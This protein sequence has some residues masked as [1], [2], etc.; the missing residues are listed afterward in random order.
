M[1]DTITPTTQ[2]KRVLRRKKKPLT[3]K[4]KLVKESTEKRFKIEKLVFVWQEKLFSH[5]KIPLQTLERAAIYLQPKTY[6]EVV[7][8]RAVQAWCGYPLCPDSPQTEALQ[9][10]KIS[11]SQRKVY[12]QSELAK[13]CSEDC[14]KKSKYYCIQL[15]EEPVWFR[16]L[17]LPASV[18]IVTKEQDFD[19]AIQQEKKKKGQAKSSQEIR[20]DYVQQLLGSVPKD[21]QDTLQIIEKENTA[22]P[23]LQPTQGIYDSIEGY[24]IEVKKDGK[25][26]TTF[27]L[28]KADSYQAIPKQ[29]IKEEKQDLAD[30]DDDA[31][32]ETMMM[33][34]DMNMDRADSAT[35][36]SDS[37]V[38][39][40]QTTLNNSTTVKEPI[41]NQT[42]KQ[43]TKQTAKEPSA[44]QST[45]QTTKEP[46][47]AISSK[48]NRQPSPQET[49]PIE[50]K[51]DPSKLKKPLK[52]KKSNKPELSLFGTIWT[53]LDYMTTKATRIYLYELEQNKQRLDPSTLLKDSR[54][55]EAS[56][57]RGQIL[58]E[59]VLDTYS[60]LRAQLDIKENLEDDIVNVIKTFRLSDASMVALNA[61][62]CYM[63]SLVLTKSLADILLDDRSWQQTF[64][65]CCH[66]VDQSTD[67]INACV[68][69]LKVASV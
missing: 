29:P 43:S 10:Y 58:S 13:Y 61:A 48:E 22:P 39:Q 30:P 54:V 63:F 20:Q 14:F 33:L 42:A 7:E 1:S 21:A 9:K 35:T 59:R 32:F 55:D 66:A 2:R 51:D 18:H 25:R 15:S 57:L 44:K 56:Y 65:H 17:S 19:L 68:R 50:I 6:D 4:Q 16:D 5:A 34:K 11:L 27:V 45:K 37:N 41:T 12:D 31:M 53:M 26:P 60:T 28:K 46:P 3:P 64:E 62:Q 52:K 24:R 69:V 67:T 40:E 8:E 36:T 23:T 49:I 38:L 47:T